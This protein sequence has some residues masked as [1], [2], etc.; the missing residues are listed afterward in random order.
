MQQRRGELVNRPLIHSFNIQVL[1]AGYNSGCVLGAGETKINKPIPSKKF[2]GVGNQRI[3]Q[4][5]SVAG[6]LRAENYVI[7]LK[8]GSLEVKVECV[9]TFK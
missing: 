5:C 4:E 9:Q 8:R 1:S 2:L 6:P 7:D 3:K